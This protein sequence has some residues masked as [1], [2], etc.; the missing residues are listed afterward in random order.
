MN[1][2]LGCLLVCRVVDDHLNPLQRGH[3]RG[4]FC[5]VC[6]KEVQ[7]SPV[8]QRQLQERNHPAVG[9]FV[10]LCNPCGMAMHARLSEVPGKHVITA[11]SPTAA[12]RVEEWLK[13]NS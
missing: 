10:I 2:K 3:I 8:G 5:A 13:N 4:H 12:A 11:V 6:Q 1:G 7:I 9:A